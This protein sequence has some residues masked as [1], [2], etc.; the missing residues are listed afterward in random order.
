MARNKIYTYL[1]DKLTMSN[2]E[3]LK[4]A[5]KSVPSV[6]EV[7]IKVNS[8][9]LEVTARKEVEQEVAMACS[10]AGCALRTKVSSRKAS[11]YA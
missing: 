4:K 6:E 5:L 3:V 7:T 11:Y 9:V 10:V 1:V 8:G 2:A